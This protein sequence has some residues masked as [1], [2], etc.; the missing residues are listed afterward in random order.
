MT[1]EKTLQS[2]IESYPELF[3]YFEEGIRSE[4]REEIVSELNLMTCDSSP[5]FKTGYKMAVKDAIERINNK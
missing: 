5:E 2:L 1:K 3:H 4:E